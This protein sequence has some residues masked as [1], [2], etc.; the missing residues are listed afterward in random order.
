[1]QSAPLDAETLRAVLQAQSASL[2]VRVTAATVAGLLFLFVLHAVRKRKLGEEFTPIWLLASLSILV[3]SVS[4]EL[5]VWITNL[6][7]AWTPSSTV[8]FF[9]IVFL[10][11]ISLVYAIHLTRLSREVRALAQDLALLRAGAKA[12]S[13]GFASGGD[14]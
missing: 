14:R 12:S 13:G 2:P 8:F 3:V 10:I 9:G 5:L 4:F 6:I 11:G 1:M 7:G